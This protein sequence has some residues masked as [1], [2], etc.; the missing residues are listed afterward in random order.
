MAFTVGFA[1]TISCELQKILAEIEF[2]QKATYINITNFYVNFRKKKIAKK[3]SLKWIS[4]SYFHLRNQNMIKL[5]NHFFFFS[6]I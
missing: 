2:S 5:N 6:K 1:H 4:F 3:I